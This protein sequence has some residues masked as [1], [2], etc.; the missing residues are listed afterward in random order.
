MAFAVLGA[1]QARADSTTI[2]IF[3]FE[4][5]SNDR[6]LDWLGEGVSELM[7][8]RLRP[9][10]GVYTFARDERLSAF[11]RLGIPEATIVSRATALKLGWDMGADHIVTGRFSGESGNFQ[12][13]ARLIDMETGG[14]VEISAQGK[15]DEI[16][17]MS[18]SVT[19]QVLSNIVPG[20]RSI[21]ADYTDRPPVPRSAFENYVRGILSQD[22]KKRIELLETA[23]RLHPQYDSAVLQLGR[24]HYLQH[25]FKNSNLW[26]RKMPESSFLR[27]QA[28]FLVGLNYFHLNDYTRAATALETIPS[29]YEV[30]LNRG[31]ALFQKGDTQA[32]LAAWEQAVEL[33]PLGSD[34]FFNLGYL[35]F[36]K[37]DFESAV[38]NL[39]QSLKNHGRDS[40]ALFLLG[41]SYERLGRIEESQKAISQASRLSQRVE[42]WMR[43]PLPD[44]IRIATTM[45]ARSHDETWTPERLARRAGRE[46]LSQ[47]LESIQT[48]IDF[49]LFGDALR[50]LKDV[51]RVVPQSSEANLLLEEVHR[52]QSMR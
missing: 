14:A 45:S 3:P 32:A 52:Q 46:D 51:I 47:W 2:L 30:L 13:T 12:L 31:A 19:R 24:A 35:S 33:Q 17:P 4:N 43:Q 40:E 39:S 48:E 6:T 37:G 16:I 20:A 5:A 22:L 21:E 36:R 28:Q 38:K 7:I 42:R 27:H 15:L 1:R 23:I 8:E 29:N 10:A 34:A 11:D 50:D 26:L 44:L 9:E 25:D 49:Y 41:R 18:M